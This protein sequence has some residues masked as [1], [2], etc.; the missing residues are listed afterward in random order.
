MSFCGSG[1]FEA[2]VAIMPQFDMGF[3]RVMGSVYSRTQFHAQVY[4]WQHDASG[5]A[6]HIGRGHQPP[7]ADAVANLRKQHSDSVN[8]LSG[9]ASSASGWIGGTGGGRGHISHQALTVLEHT[10]A[11]DAGVLE[12]R[13]TMPC[14]LHL[15]GDIA[16]RLDRA[17]EVDEDISHRRLK[18]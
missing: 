17:C 11:D 1:Q 10:P 14:H 6:V 3:C 13:L 5:W 9:R 12:V 8:S 4:G 16:V 2:T 18:V 15:P 7:G